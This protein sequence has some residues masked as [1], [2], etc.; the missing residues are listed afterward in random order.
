MKSEK[1]VNSLEIFEDSDTMMKVIN[2][3]F[4]DDYSDANFYE[5]NEYIR[6][7]LDNYESNI[8]DGLL[9]EEIEIT[10]D[11]IDECLKPI[12][13]A[14]ERIIT[15]KYIDNL[16][17]YIDQID[18]VFLKNYDEIKKYNAFF[19]A[20]IQN[21]CIELGLDYKMFNRLIKTQIN[22]ICE[23]RREERSFGAICFKITES[24]YVNKNP[25]YGFKFIKLFLNSVIDTYGKKV[26]KKIIERYN[27]FTSTIE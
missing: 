2:E 7:W 13:D 25:E 9:K 19:L 3:D 17:C 23:T 11:N 16:V 8:R 22:M 24:D 5:L 1:E 10:E 20:F 27:I 4:K 14:R 12:C 26:F 18:M 6:E 21:I 15:E